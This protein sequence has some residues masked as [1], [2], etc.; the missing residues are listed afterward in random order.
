M[1]DPRYDIID[2]CY[3]KLLKKLTPHDYDNLAEIVKRG[4]FIR[5]S[6]SLEDYRLPLCFIPVVEYQL[7]E[8][9]SWFYTVKSSNPSLERTHLRQKL[10]TYFRA[11]MTLL[12]C[13]EDQLLEVMVSK[14]VLPSKDFKLLT[15]Q[16]ELTSALARYK[17]CGLHDRLVEALNSE[18]SIIGMLKPAYGSPNTNL[19]Q[20][21]VE[22]FAWHPVYVAS[23]DSLSLETFFFDGER[24]RRMSNHRPPKRER[25]RRERK[26]RDIL[27]EAM[28]LTI[29]ELMCCV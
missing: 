17:R 10:N 13:S 21:I 23:R 7:L 2:W 28:Y 9:H 20:S 12:D 25:K 26:R 6:A 16:K 5:E 4:T 3:F 18:E 15:T 14:G 19:L 11:L 24:K 22:V 1:F 29:P 27:A 8:D